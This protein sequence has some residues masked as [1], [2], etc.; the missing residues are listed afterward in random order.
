M[1]LSAVHNQ[2][3]CLRGAQRQHSSHSDVHDNEREQSA[4]THAPAE[5]QPVSTPSM[6]TE[7]PDVTHHLYCFQMHCRLWAHANYNHAKEPLD[8]HT[9][10]KSILQS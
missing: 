9:G 6:T 1:L 4:K 7:L 8:M 2:Q 5:A 10:Q 3:Q